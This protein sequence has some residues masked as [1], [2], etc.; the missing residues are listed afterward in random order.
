MK[1]TKETK[2]CPRCKRRVRSLA[3]SGWCRPCT[4]KWNLRGAPMERIPGKRCLDCG[5]PAWRYVKTGAPVPC[6]AV[7]GP[8][9]GGSR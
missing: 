1:T 3:L 8:K 7:P 4:L 2:R 5:A 9:K 6:F